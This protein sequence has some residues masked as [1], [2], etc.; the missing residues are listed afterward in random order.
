MDLEIILY[1]ILGF[2]LFNVAFYLLFAFVASYFV[3]TKTL[4]R[5]SPEQWSREP[6]LEGLEKQ[7]YEEGL[8]WQKEHSD[9]KHEV[10]IE[11]D[12]T[13]LFGEYYD[14]G[15]ERCVIILAGRSES[16]TQGYYFAEPYTKYGF[17]M[18]FLDPRAHGLSEGEFNTVGFEE[19]KDV[20][21]W[22]RFI[23]D[24]FGVKSI[25]LHG[26]CI[27]A[28]SGT[29]AMTSEDCPDYIDGIVAEGMFINFGES[30]K[31]H[32]I[33]RKKPIFLVYGFINMWMKHYTG[34]K[35]DF[36]P[37]DVIA[38]QTKPMMF[39]QGKKDLYS[40]PEYAQKM[41]DLCPAEQKFIEWFDEGAHS[42]L[43]PVNREQYDIAVSR[44][45]ENVYDTA[46]IK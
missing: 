36:G 8:E 40:L 18:L 39:L 17:N 43:R 27:G 16:L 42:Q 29:L 2:I 41:F 31:N 44:Y 26:I 7:M 35:M 37:I 11:R 25:T 45:I 46:N 32:M 30:L 23:H 9:K 1:I 22:A 15:S 13:K 38:K 28:A 4:Q 10:Q 14:F 20:I 6:V 5:K 3:Y 12:G 24:T 19:S 21:V 33:E 34:Y